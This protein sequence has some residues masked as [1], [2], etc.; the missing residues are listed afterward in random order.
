MKKT[1]AFCP[2]MALTLA[3]CGAKRKAPL[4]RLLPLRLPLRARSLKS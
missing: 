1:I 2:A 4:R 3:A